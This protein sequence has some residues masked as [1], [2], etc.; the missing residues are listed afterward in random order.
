MNRIESNR[1]MP[2]TAFAEEFFFA[3]PP[4]E[5]EQQ[6]HEAA[7]KPPSVRWERKKIKS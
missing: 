4:Q 2:L 3:T 1:M 6:I 5:Q 7:Q